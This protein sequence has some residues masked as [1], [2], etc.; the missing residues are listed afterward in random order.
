MEGPGR[1]TVHQCACS[2]CRSRSDADVIKYHKGINRVAVELN[3]SNRRL[4]VG[5]LAKQL[6]RGGIQRL[7]EITGMSRMTIRRGVREI[8]RRGSRAS[9]R[10]RCVGGGRKA[11]EKKVPAW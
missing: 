1:K 5:L 11:L 8:S 4:F 9:K 10:V 2:V 6:G 7:A 3:E